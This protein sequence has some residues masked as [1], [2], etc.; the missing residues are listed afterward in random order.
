MSASATWGSTLIWWVAL[1]WW[2]QWN[3]C[4]KWLV[5]SCVL[6]FSSIELLL[7]LCKCVLCMCSW[8]VKEVHMHMYVGLCKGMKLKLGVSISQFSTLCF[9]RVSY[10]ACSSVIL[11]TN[12]P[13][14]LF[15]L[16]IPVAGIVNGWHRS[17]AF[18]WVLRIQTQICV[19]RLSSPVLL[20]IAFSYS[21]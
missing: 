9:E 19:N 20:S 14:G 2:C 18:T 15:F 13:G 10:W 1:L 17:L 12:K 7:S 8:G 3:L 21:S 16:S 6:C 5:L 11:L 4:F